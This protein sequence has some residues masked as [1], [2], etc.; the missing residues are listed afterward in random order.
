MAIT[1]AEGILIRILL[2]TAISEITKKVQGMSP[3]E[4]NKAILE[5]EAKTEELIKEI[6]SH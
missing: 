5:A 4:V 1:A 6:D 2:D 3:E